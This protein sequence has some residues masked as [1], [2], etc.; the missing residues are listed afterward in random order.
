MSLASLWTIKLEGQ[1][2][3][4]CLSEMF[5]TSE[6]KIPLLANSIR[7]SITQVPYEF[8]SLPICQPDPVIY[9]SLNLG[10]VLS[11]DRIVNTLM[12]VRSVSVVECF[13]DGIQV[14]VLEPDTIVN[15]CNRTMSTA[16]KELLSERIRQNYYVEMFAIFFMSSNC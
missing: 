11:G 16:D 13:S 8:Y 7:S 9:D 2:Y 15:W 12:H 1:L 5:L 10:E 3:V 6:S 14:E 4:S